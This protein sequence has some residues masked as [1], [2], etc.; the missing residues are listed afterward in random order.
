MIRHFGCSHR[1]F[2]NKPSHP[3]KHRNL[4]VF[5]FPLYYGAILAI[6]CATILHYMQCFQIC[7]GW[8]QIE[9]IACAFSCLVSIYCLLVL[10]DPVNVFIITSLF[11][12]VSNRQLSLNT[13]CRISDKNKT[14]ESHNR[15]DYSFKFKIVVYEILL[16]DDKPQTNKDKTKM[17]YIV[18]S[19]CFF[20]VYP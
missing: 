11:Y 4:R 2:V 17:Y 1:T 16:W 15:F 14:A 12:S 18:T 13:F 20:T 3:F 9:Q 7:I 10:V 6:L 8:E 19:D 5:A